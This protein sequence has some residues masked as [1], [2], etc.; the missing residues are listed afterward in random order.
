MAQRA[1]SFTCPVCGAT[2]YGDT[3]RYRTRS[4]ASCFLSRELV[5][6]ANCGTRSAYPMPADAEL[7]AYYETYSLS[8]N[9]GEQLPLLDAQ[10]K[11]RLAFFS[12]LLPRNQSV[13]VLDI[14]AGYGCI[15]THLAALVPDLAYEAIEWDA[16]SVEYLRANPAVKRVLGVLDRTAQQYDL[17]ILAHFLEHL[18][19]PGSYLRTLRSHLHAKSVIFIE[20]PNEDYRYKE[21]NEPHLVFFSPSTIR[22]LL[23]LQ[24]FEVLRSQTFGMP[25]SEL[26][27]FWGQVNLRKKEI[28]RIRKQDRE[29]GK[30]MLRQFLEE[31]KKHTERLRESVESPGPDR[32]WIRLV[33]RL[34]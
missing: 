33:A 21:S 12:D 31:R 8:E 17:V 24:G 30:H 32:H 5:N 23:Q 7:R 9:R 3:R 15:A 27:A 29:R 13:R 16:D 6:C 20:V 34:A 19:Q 14:G 2:R 1:A 26:Q 4:D 28:N 22:M 25:A 11:A 18:P 10:A